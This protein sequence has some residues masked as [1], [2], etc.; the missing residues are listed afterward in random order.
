MVQEKKETRAVLFQRLGLRFNLVVYAAGDRLTA[1]A[2][3]TQ[4]D[5]KA[6]RPTAEDVIAVLFESGLKLVED[7]GARL[8][9]ALAGAPP[10][11]IPEVVIAEGVPPTKGKAA[12]AKW[13]VDLSEESHVHIVGDQA[14][15][16][17][18]RQIAQVKEGDPVL[19]VIPPTKGEP[20]T[21]VQGQPIEGLPGDDLPLRWGENVAFDRETRVLRAKVAGRVRHASGVVWVDPVYR[22]ET[23]VDFNTGNVSFEGDISISGS[24]QDGFEVKAAK[25]VTIFGSVFAATVIAGGS[26]TIHEGINGHGQAKLTAGGTIASKYVKDATLQ[27]GGDLRI[28]GEIFSSTVRVNGKIFVAR[29]TIVGGDVVALRGIEARTLGSPMLVPTRITLGIDPDVEKRVK[30]LRQQIANVGKQIERIYLTIKP[31]VDNPGSIADLPDSRKD[32]VR[33]LLQSLAALRAQKA[34]A[35]KE[36]GGLDLPAIAVKDLKVFVSKEVYAKVTISMGNIST[37]FTTSVPGPCTLIAD[38]EKKR[39]A[40][41]PM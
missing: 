35:E 5:A 18:V 17:D 30:D 39:I 24:V 34:A 21:D 31:Y 15:F 38:E 36:L 32:W 14:D 9:I 29:G 13:F 8:T 23:D 33:S 4:T 12:E 26:I 11:E 6:E 7:L 10:L 41:K 20:G 27:A 16:R 19:E 28:T 37:A 2:R 40:A 25:N 1:G 22:I 3:V